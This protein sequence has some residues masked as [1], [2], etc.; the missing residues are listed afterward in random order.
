ML[1]LLSANYYV[2]YDPAIW[3]QFWNT[4]IKSI[5]SASWLGML[6]FAVLAGISIFGIVLRYWFR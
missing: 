3:N 6:V 2:P 5:G 1:T 4:A